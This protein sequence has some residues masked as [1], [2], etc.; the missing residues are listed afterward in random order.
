MQQRDSK[1][2]IGI[3]SMVGLGYLAYE[4]KCILKNEKADR[5]SNNIVKQGI[6]R[7]GILGLM[8]EANGTLENLSGGKA[9]FSALLGTE[10]NQR[11]QSRSA[12]AGFAGPSWSTGENIVTIA[13]GISTA[14]YDDA[15]ITAIRRMIP[16]QNLFYLAPAFNYAE[17][18][19][20]K[21]IK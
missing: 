20:K 14:Q 10:I 9:G 8:G 12:L 7:S 5:S 4:L 2:A 13:N 15:Q 1:A 16:Y 21:S 3:A 19:A 18:K 6:D 17:E 11:F